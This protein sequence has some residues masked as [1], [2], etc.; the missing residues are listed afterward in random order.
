[1]PVASTVASYGIYGNL[2]PASQ[3]AGV[4][5]TLSGAASS[6]TTSDSSGNFGFS[7]LANGSYTVTPAK[8]GAV[9]TPTSQTVTVDGFN[10]KAV[11]FSA[12]AQTW[13]LSGTLSPAASGSGATL[14]LGGAA[15]ATT[16]ANSSGAYSFSGLANG[17]YSVTPSKSSYVF[18]P[19]AQAETI[20]GASVSNVNFT[21]SAAPVTVSLSPVTATLTTGNTQQFTATVTGSTNTAVTWT[22][23][24]GSVSSSGLYT[25]PNTTGT[26]AVTATSAAETSASAS[27]T[28]T[29]TATSSTSVLQG[30]TNVE[31]QVGALA[32]GQAEAFQAPATAS[33]S[34]QS[35][36]VY[37]DS[38]STASQLVVGLY[39]DSGGHPGALLSHGSN[40]SPVAGAWNPILIPSATL[41][42][43]TPYWIA[44]LGTSSGTL[45][46]RYAT[47][48]TC[49]SETSAQSSLTSLPSTWTTGTV[50]TICPASAFGDST[51][52]IFFD[53]FPAGI[54][55]SPFWTV[56][57]RQGDYTNDELEC[58]LPANVTQNSS[59]LVE[60]AEV[61]T[62]TCGDSTHTPYSH[63]YT[64]GA[65]G[66]AT[67]NYT[68]G[69]IEVRAQMAGGVGPWPAIWLLGYECENGW[70][71]NGQSNPATCNWPQPGSDEIDFVEIYGGQPTTV[72]EHVIT[73]SYDQ[74]CAPSASNVNANWH[75][76]DMVWSAGS[77]VWEIDGGTTCSIQ[78][79]WVPDSAMFLIINVAVGGTSGGTP[80]NSTF[81]QS[82][83]VE[84]V[85]IHQ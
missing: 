62:Y 69:T 12:Q 50:G 71:L 35:L 29:V 27:A 18:S 8:S 63:S 81:P 49:A 9:I 68:Y 4:T 65:I 77:L 1:P 25:A 72:E 57:N 28:V 22:A 74:G 56:L 14:T 60:T 5:V 45:A 31:A 10:V 33:G 51:K 61:Q 16:T 80:N 19:S 6:T 13:S 58:Y 20:S 44:I 42:S 32:M 73:A 34:V 41:T 48:S 24:A 83:T 17:T 75:V 54:A 7:G 53:N 11:D 3:G 64:S 38:T 66:W 37:L 26:Y 21:V 84:Y 70:N 30:D 40:T 43:G 36:V 82:T 23:S 67:F 15:S 39:A 55:P 47:P 52:V 79:S 46:Y 76:Y 2:S 59:G 78:Q 85:K